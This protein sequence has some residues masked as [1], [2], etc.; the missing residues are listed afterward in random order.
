MRF[1]IDNQLPPA[2]ARFIATDLAG[3][4]FHVLDVGLRDATDAAVWDYASENGFILI[5]KDEDFVTLFSQ[6][7]T[8]RLLWLRVRNCRRVRLLE[9]IESRWSTIVD[10]FEGGERFIELR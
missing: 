3:Q 6:L 8:A 5:S 9:I 7:P 1:L 4:A 2:L 10:R